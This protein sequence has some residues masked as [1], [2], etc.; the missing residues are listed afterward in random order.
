MR[1]LRHLEARP[2]LDA[3]RR[4]V[5]DGV[6]DAVAQ[7]DGHAA[8][9]VADAH[10]AQQADLHEVVD[11]H[12]GQRLDRLE[13][14][15]HAAA[16]L[17]VEVALGV[18]V[19]EP[20][21]GVD[22]VHPVT[23]DVHV[24]VTGD[25]DERRSRAVG[26]HVHDHER[27]GVEAPAVATDLQFAHLCGRHAGAVVVADDEQILSLEHRVVRRPDG[28][29]LVA[30]LAQPADRDGVDVVDAPGGVPQ[31]ADVHEQRRRQRSRQHHR[32]P[33]GDQPRPSSHIGNLQR[34][35]CAAPDIGRRWRARTRR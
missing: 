26:G 11:G 30:R 23:R 7:I 16:A 34:V 15:A 21:R 22:L 28:V 19:A 18:V 24:R 25:R 3:D 27:V 12:S 29:L 13:E 8:D 5:R 35:C 33:A 32:R 6:V 10:E 4:V 2:A 20:V 9:R 1:P 17:L 14:Q 31:H